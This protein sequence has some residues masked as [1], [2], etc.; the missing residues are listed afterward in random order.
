MLQE[1]VNAGYGDRYV[2]ALLDSGCDILSKP[3]K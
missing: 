2:S 1:A 3:T